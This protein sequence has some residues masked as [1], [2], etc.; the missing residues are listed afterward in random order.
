MKNLVC[1]AWKTDEA[2]IDGDELPLG[3][4]IAPGMGAIRSQ[5]SGNVIAGR[6]GVLPA[7]RFADFWRSE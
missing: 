2:L 6:L 7:K 5:Y 3:P 4:G 1:D